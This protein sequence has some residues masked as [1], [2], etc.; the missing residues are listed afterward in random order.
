MDKTEKTINK[1]YDNLGY[2]DLYF[3]NVLFFI[4]LNLII[5]IICAYNSVLIN[6]QPIKNDWVAQR[7]N[8]L[9][10]PFAG[11]INKPDDKSAFEFTEENFSFCVQNILTEMTGYLLEPITFLTADLGKFFNELTDSFNNVRTFLSN[12]RTYVDV[13]GVEI[14][15]RLANIMIPL[16]TIIIKVKDFFG[17]FKGMLATAL[18]TLIGS[19]SALKSLFGAIIQIIILCLLIS[20]GMIIAA[21]IIGFFFF[22]VG[23]ACCRSYCNL[24]YYFSFSSC[25]V[26][27][28]E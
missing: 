12:V 28:Y 21:W 3:G 23:G 26:C 7:C 13:I 27:I 4:V 11:I 2:N 18:Y 8:P 24:Y 5:F 17:K 9:V 19:Y 20:F 1:L 22:S 16:Q 14:M 10:M 25:H 6:A 15:G